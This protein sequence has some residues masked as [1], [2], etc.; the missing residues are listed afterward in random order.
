[1]L[2]EDVKN[3]NSQ[4]QRKQGKTVQYIKQCMQKTKWLITIFN[5]FKNIDYENMFVRLGFDFTFL[6]VVTARNP[7][8]IDQAKVKQLQNK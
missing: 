4:G 3:G 2:Q 6:D 7:F 1:M 5:I 8:R